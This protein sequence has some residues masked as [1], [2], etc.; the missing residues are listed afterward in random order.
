LES[1]S[2]LGSIVKINVVVFERSSASISKFV[3]LSSPFVLTVNVPVETGVPAA[4]LLDLGA[5][6]GTIIQPS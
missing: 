5:G 1:E 4:G 3:W 6:A 2:G